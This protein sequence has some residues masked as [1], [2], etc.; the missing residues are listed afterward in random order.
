MRTARSKQIASY[1][2]A[3]VQR[4]HD[5]VSI[6]RASHSRRRSALA[7]R[8]THCRTVAARSRHVSQAQKH[9]RPSGYNPGGVMK[10][11]SRVRQKTQAKKK[12]P[13]WKIPRSAAWWKRYWA[14]HATPSC[15]V[16]INPGGPLKRVSPSASRSSLRASA[17]RPALRAVRATKTRSN[18]LKAQR[19]A[20]PS[21][22]RRGR[23]R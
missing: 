5:P 22:G 15:A 14:T 1:L 23:R 11:V 19:A 10:K 6:R 7:A 4:G 16:K 18:V 8:R 17:A 2:K 20:A 9:A 12:I 21:R 13:Y 3:S